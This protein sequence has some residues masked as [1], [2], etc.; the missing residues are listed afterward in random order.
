M[1]KTKWMPLDEAVKHVMKV[2]KCSHFDAIDKLVRANKDGKLP[3]KTVKTKS[4]LKKLSHKE[5]VER[6]D[7]DPA[8]VAM[9]L[10]EFRRR[11]AFTH[12]EV[13]GELRAGRLIAT[14]TDATWFRMKATGEVM[15]DEIMIQM[16][17][18]I[19][20]LT[21]PKTPE[22]LLAQWRGNLEERRH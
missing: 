7:N 8:S 3:T 5:A 4:P 6:L 19:N 15:A 13:L 16:D 11:G 21:N 17:Q 1:P 10:T 14:A 22:H 12:D 2:E 9:T 20:W 18:V